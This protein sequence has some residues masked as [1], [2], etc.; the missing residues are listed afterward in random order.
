MAARLRSWDLIFYV[1]FGIVVTSSVRI[2]GVLLVFSYLI[3]PAAVA[4]LLPPRCRRAC[5]S[6]GAW[7][8]W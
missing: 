4:A 2:A 5:S 6:A 7:A 8:P 1:T 3:V